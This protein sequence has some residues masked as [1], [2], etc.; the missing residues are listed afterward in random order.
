MSPHNG[1]LLIAML[2]VQPMYSVL[3]DALVKKEHL[4]WIFISHTASNEVMPIMRLDAINS[5]L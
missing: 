1:T 5:T 2:M 4:H 3:S